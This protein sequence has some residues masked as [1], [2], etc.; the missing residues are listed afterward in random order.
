MTTLSA[1]VNALADHDELHPTAL[2][3][4]R[5]V[6]ANGKQGLSKAQLAVYDQYIKPYVEVTCANED[7]EFKATYDSVLA[8]I[9]TVD[10]L[11]EVQGVCEH[12]EHIAEQNAKDD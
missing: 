6:S 9:Q 7:C 4:A 8:S 10:E 11:C 12:C 3:I 5:L 2:G 1:C